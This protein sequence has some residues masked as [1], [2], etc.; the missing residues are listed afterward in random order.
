MGL[1][2][3]STALCDRIRSHHEGE[4]YPSHTAMEKR[5]FV[6]RPPTAAAVTVRHRRGAVTGRGGR[7]DAADAGRPATVDGATTAGGGAGR[8]STPPPARPPR[9]PTPRPARRSDRRNRPRSP[10]RRDRAGGER[11][12][13]V[14]GSD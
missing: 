14:G 2:S 4:A 3:L 13:G 10:S 1:A 11:P 8:A 9:A 6:D 5:D 7:G 12:G